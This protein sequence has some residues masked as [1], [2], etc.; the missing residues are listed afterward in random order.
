[1]KRVKFTLN[2]GFVNAQC[3]DVQ[4]YDDDATQEEIDQDWEQWVWDYIY[5]SARFLTDGEDE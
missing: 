2:I 1:M 4:E 3:V 5:G